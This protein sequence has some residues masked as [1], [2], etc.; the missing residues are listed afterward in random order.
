MNWP[1]VRTALVEIDFTGWCT[2]EVEGGDQERLADIAKRMNQ[3][4]AL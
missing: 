3:C 1:E 4:M 2:A